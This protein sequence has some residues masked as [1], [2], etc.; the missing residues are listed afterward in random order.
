MKNSGK[1]RLIRADVKFLA[2]LTVANY[3]K[4]HRCLP[5]FQEVDRII[6]NISEKI[7]NPKVRAYIRRLRCIGIVDSPIHP[8]EV[9]VEERDVNS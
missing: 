9:L 3:L 1:L 7:D 5:S 4:Y 2:S 6:F 8:T